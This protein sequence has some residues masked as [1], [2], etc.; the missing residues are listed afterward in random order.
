MDITKNF[1]NFR[2]LSDE[3][4]ETRIVYSCAFCPQNCYN[5]IC[6][7]RKKIANFVNFSSVLNRGRKG[8]GLTA[9]LTRATSVKVGNILTK[10]ERVEI[11]AAF[12]SNQTNLFMLVKLLDSKVLRKES[13]F[14][15]HSGITN[16]ELYVRRGYS[17]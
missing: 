13:Q 3:H 9:E 16:R 14:Y 4:I 17:F 6:Y 2:K 8:I 7:H 5:F 11:T 15:T 10:E 12:A 1:C